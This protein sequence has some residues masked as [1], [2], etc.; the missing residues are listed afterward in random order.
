VTVT[1]DARGDFVGR[2]FTA[3]AAR[4]DRM[5]DIVLRHV[6]RDRAIRVLDIGCG[7][8]S[9]LFRLA[10]M[11]PSAVLVGIDISP[12]NIRAATEQQAGR[13]SAARLRFE[14]ADYLEYRA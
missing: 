13:A 3:P 1:G 7:T 2:T 12:A 11:L 10:D 8:G 14:A 9:L 6:P 5:R 4:S